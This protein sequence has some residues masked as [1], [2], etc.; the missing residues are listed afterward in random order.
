MPFV[1]IGLDHTTAGIELRERVA[2]ADTDIALALRRLTD[3]GDGMLDQAA[4]LST[5]NRVE[6]YGVWRSRPAERELASFLACYHGLDPSQIAS[7]LY[8]HR[9]RR[10]AHHLAATAAGMHS[11]LLG[12][13]QIL[14]QVRNALDHALAVGTA[15]TELRRMFESAIAT[16]RRVRSETA[17]GRGATS[18]PYAGVELARRRLGTLQ[19]A[20]VMLIGTGEMAQLV[21]KQ[22]VKRGTKRLLVVGRGP[23]RAEALAESYGGD[24]VMV[25]R[26][27]EA[28]L[29]SDVVISATGAPEP[30][31]RRDQLRRALAHR[32]VDGMPL[33]VID[34]S[35]PR[36]VDPAT[37]DLSGI[38][39]H[40][41]DE[42]R[43]VVERSLAQRRTALAEAEV[44]VGREVTRFADWLDR[45]QAA[46]VASPGS[47]RA[48]PAVI[49]RILQGST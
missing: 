16:G 43:G 17:L 37:S 4:I 20:T 12:E 25:D 31:V 30:V 9:D 46:P 2:F 44:I 19:G 35:V 7:S 27:D 48:K 49:G 8:V 32:R 36:A 28:L 42:L 21:A 39:V 45:R 26:L 24:A 11:L 40:T 29:W 41:I 33:L 10:V 5:C 23:S 34:L 38:E 22:L 3:Q 6:L 14:G 1:A 15:G 13:A 47:A 18:F